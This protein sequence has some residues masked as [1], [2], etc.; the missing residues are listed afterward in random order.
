MAAREMKTSDHSKPA[1][2]SKKWLVEKRISELGHFVVGEGRNMLLIHGGPG[3]AVP[4]A[5]ERT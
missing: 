4:P 1:V 3:P 5:D 2:D